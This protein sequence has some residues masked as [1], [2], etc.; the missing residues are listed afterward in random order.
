MLEEIR[1]EFDG[2]FTGM[3][4]NPIVVPDSDSDSKADPK[5]EVHTTVKFIKCRDPFECDVEEEALQSYH[6]R[7]EVGSLIPLNANRNRIQDASDSKSCFACIIPTSDESNTFF[8]EEGLEDMRGQV[9]RE[10]A[11]VGWQWYNPEMTRDRVEEINEAVWA[12][13]EWRGFCMSNSTRYM[14]QAIPQEEE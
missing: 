2:L 1:A 3:E 9:Q 7:M 4:Q 5:A 12:S 11:R 14:V 10:P 8:M 6:A 13:N